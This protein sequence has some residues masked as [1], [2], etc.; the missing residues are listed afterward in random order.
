MSSRTPVEIADRLSRKRALASA[1]AAAGFL[2]VQVLTHPFFGTD[3]QH[4]RTG[5]WA[6]NA[7]ALLLILATGGGLVY[8]HQ[9]RE[10]LR[11]ELS[12]SHYRTAV[13][14]GYWI[15]MAVAMGLIVLPISRQ[16]GAQE[17]IYLIVTPSIAAA[18]LTFAYLEHRAHRDA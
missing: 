6:V 12:R 14:A 10:L 18:L 13:I 9:L 8:N 17:A 4:P 15:A 11:D 7:F 2:L 1:I 3:A 5:M 16:M